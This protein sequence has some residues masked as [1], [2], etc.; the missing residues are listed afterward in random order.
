MKLT[1]TLVFLICIFFTARSQNCI[2]QTDPNTG[3]TTT[4]VTTIL[5]TDSTLQ[6]ARLSFIRSGTGTSVGLAIMSPSRFSVSDLNAIQ[7]KITF[8]DQTQQ[9][10]SGS[11]HTHVTTVANGTAILFEGDISATET[12]ALKKNPP[13]Q[14][15]LLVNGHSIS[16]QVLRDKTNQITANLDC[17]NQ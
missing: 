1:L 10:V 5:E 17:L 4:S 3:K 11:G 12:E 8:A 7:L 15:D 13:A 2:T 16:I 9:T 14:L 6:S